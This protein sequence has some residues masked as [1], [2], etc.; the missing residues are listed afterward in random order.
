MDLWKLLHSFGFNSKIVDLMEA[1]YMDTC[2]C[3]N[4]DGVMSDWT[5]GSG[6]RQGSRS[7]LDLFLGPMDHMMERT[8]HRGMLQNG[9]TLGDEIFTDL[10]FTDDIALFAE[11]LEV[12]ILALS[13]IEEEEAAFGLHI[14]WSK[15]KIVQ[16]CNPAT[17]SDGQV[18]MVDSFVY[19]GS[20]IDSTGGI[21]DSASDTIGTELHEPPGKKNLEI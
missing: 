20:T 9:V 7:A 16:F 10:H 19:L 6:V 13:V 8:I 4:V 5:V 3:V 17:C 1:L 2:G 14:N 15:T 12:L 21:R 18:E 11:M